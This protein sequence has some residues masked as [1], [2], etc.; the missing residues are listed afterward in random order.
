MNYIEDFLKYLKII[1]KHSEYTI[2]NYRRDLLELYQF[3]NDFIHF[4]EYDRDCYLEYLYKRGLSRNSISR[5]LSSIRTFFHYMK[6][7]EFVCEN[8]FS[9]IRNPKKTIGLPKYAKDTDLE[10]IFN[11]FDKS[12]PLGQRNSLLL[13]M[14]YATGVRVSELVSIKISDI[15]FYDHTIKIIGKGKKMRMV[16]YGSYC[17]DMLNIYLNDGYCKLN[18]KNIDYLFLNK[19]GGRLSSR[20][21]RVVLD[22]AV[23]KCQ[24]DYHISPH[25]LRHTFATD[26]LNAGADLMT[27]KELLGHS[28]INTTGIY[29]HVSNEQLRKVYDFSHPRAKE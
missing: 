20:Y 28:S 13:E 2:E 16:F 8:Y 27:V 23:R 1:R 7:E 10:R 19:N 18:S 26:L 6:E 22:D 5:K 29:T 9:E 21:V 17:E 3:K 25:T 12:T 4:S 24:V 15:N 14:L 11:V